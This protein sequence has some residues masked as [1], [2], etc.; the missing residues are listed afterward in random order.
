MILFEFFKKK[1]NK[2]EVIKPKL[3]LTS[4]LNEN[5]GKDDKVF[6]RK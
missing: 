4:I 5:I 6:L 2:P 1:K 3:E